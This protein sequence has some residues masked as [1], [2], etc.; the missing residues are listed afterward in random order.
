MAVT[1]AQLEE[2]YRSYVAQVN[3]TLPADMPDAEREQVLKRAL[4]EALA[5]DLAT[6]EERHKA[7]IIHGADGVVAAG[8]LHNPE[9]T[10]A[11]ELAQ[12]RQSIA[13]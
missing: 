9:V 2:R 5:S 10:H 3:D 4:D 11:E 7:T 13:A 8:G 1:Q 6:L 12:I